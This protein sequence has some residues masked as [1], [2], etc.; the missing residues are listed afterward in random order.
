MVGAASPWPDH[1]YDHQDHDQRAHAAVI[2]SGTVELKQ[3]VDRTKG[4]PP[5]D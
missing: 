3:M 1:S 5:R 4:L 2:L